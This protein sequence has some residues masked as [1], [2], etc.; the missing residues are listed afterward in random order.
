MECLELEWPFA[1]P[2][3]SH[4]RRRKKALTPYTGSVSL[5]LHLPV[6]AHYSG[7]IL[8]FLYKENPRKLKNHSIIEPLCK[9]IFEINTHG[10]YYTYVTLKPVESMYLSHGVEKHDPI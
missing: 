6:A 4:M 5:G 9:F 1:K 2:K 7:Y 10:R 8:Y 3:D